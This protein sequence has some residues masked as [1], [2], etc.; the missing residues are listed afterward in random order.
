M[1]AGPRLRHG[2]LLLGA[3]LALAACAPRGGG[4]A[5][6]TLPKPPDPYAFRPDLSGP[7]L[8]RYLDDTPRVT[9][10]SGF[11][12]EYGACIRYTYD[13]VSGTLVRVQQYETRN[14]EERL[15]RDTV[16]AALTP[17]ET[18]AVFD[19]VERIDLWGYPENVVEAPTGGAATYID[20]GGSYRLDVR[21]GGR[22]ALVRWT[23]G[24]IRHTPSGDRLRALGERIAGF[25]RAEAAMQALPQPEIICL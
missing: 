23:T 9:A 13:S 5:T 11:V 22:T 7:R 1:T 4:T 24:V 25:L 20:P 15:I 10:D 2:L 3:A 8:E 6:R 17:D 21:R 18:R 12:F 16:H 14:G 19:E